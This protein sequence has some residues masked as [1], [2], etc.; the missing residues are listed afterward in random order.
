MWIVYMSCIQPVHRMMKHET[1]GT[2]K[3]IPFS[4]VLSFSLLLAFGSF[5]QTPPAPGAGTPPAPDTATPPSSSAAVPVTVGTDANRDTNPA[6][7]KVQSADVPSNE[8]KLRQLAE[9]VEDL[10][11]KVTATKFRL[12]LL[13][14]AM[15]AEKE[16]IGG[17][18]IT[19]QHLNKMGGAFKMVRLRYM[20]DGKLIASYSDAGEKD[21]E[22]LSKK[23]ITIPVGHVSPGNVRITVFITYQGNG[24]GVFK[25]VKEWK[26]EINNSYSFNVEPG[27]DYT[28]EVKGVEKGGWTTPLDQRPSIVFQLKSQALVTKEEAKPKK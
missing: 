21:R 22:V 10:K 5:A 6:P 9:L 13:K 3:S 4:I 11:N 20:M 7:D 16:T 18:K 28:L 14:E 25:Y 17:A 15:T 19:I 27:K 23:E 8:L 24:Y 1:R 12:Q 2:M 26:W